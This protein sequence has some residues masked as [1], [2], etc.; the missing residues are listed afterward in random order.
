MSAT[1]IG[2]L[3]LRAALGVVFLAHGYNHI[4][5]G[6]KIAGTIRWFGSLG[7]RPAVVHGWMASL[8]ELGAG[9]LLLLGLATPLACAAVVGTMVVAWVTNHR[10]NGFFIF[11]PGEGYE[12]VMT[13]TLAAVALSG[14]GAG[15]I[16][17]DHALGWFEPPGW[18]GLGLGA[19]GAVAAAA[20]LAVSWR[21]APKNPDVDGL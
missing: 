1:D 8:V 19:A 11:R 7:M 13:L 9:V 20:L 15:R 18:I 5:G 12:Y 2:Q 16:S 21:P 4:F 10:K 17:L 14:I 6:G 3:V